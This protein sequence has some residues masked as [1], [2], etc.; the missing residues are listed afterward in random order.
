[1]LFGYHNL[2]WYF[3]CGVR[4]GL[5]IDFFICFRVC[6]NPPRKRMN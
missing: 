1:M 4:D 6:R 3:I 5:D 2:L